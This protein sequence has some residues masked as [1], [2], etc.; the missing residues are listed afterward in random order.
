MEQRSPGE[1]ATAYWAD[2]RTLE[3]YDRV[4]A[5][6]IGWKWEAVLDEVE[7]RAGLP[8]PAAVLDWGTGTGV[9]ARTVLRRL[10]PER[11]P[12]RLVL[13][14]RDAGA[15]EFAAEALRGEFPGLAVETTGELP[16][17][18]FDLVLASHVL[19]ELEDPEVAP[20]LAAAAAADHV[21]WVEPG[22]KATSRRLSALRATLLADHHVVAPCV[23]RGDCG[24]L[25]EHE[26]DWC[27]LFARPPAEVHTTG[28]G[29]RST[30]SCG[31]T[32]G[33][34][35]LPGAAEG[36]GGADGRSAPAGPA[37]VPEGARAP[38]PLRRR[39]GGDHPDAA[40]LGQG[41]LQGA[42][43]HGGR[44]RAHGARGQ[45]HDPESEPLVTAAGRTCTSSS[46]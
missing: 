22:S 7:A 20:L 34:V 40:T 38:R 28:S 24:V 8:A 9:A 1:A 35:L 16:S 33:A 5:A 45:R 27:H 41:A 46:P 23:H 26:R 13:L 4:F 18:A 6:R 30:A 10:G 15:R 2:R 36:G 43:G 32:C 44:A 25:A 21:L 12:T 11:R 17:E 3:L 37:A 19:D 39:R 42:E 14:D 29:A 31:S